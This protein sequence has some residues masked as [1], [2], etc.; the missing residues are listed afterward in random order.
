MRYLTVTANFMG[1]GLKD[2]FE[3]Q[4]NP[5]ELYLTMDL[6][7]EIS[8]WNKAYQPVISMSFDDRHS[9]ADLIKSLDDQGLT[10]ARK[11]KK[12]LG[13][14]YKIDYYSEGQLMHLLV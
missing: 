6:R 1:T 2:K 13:D 8:S 11:I 5:D 12:F 9:N 14:D 4:L 3:G 10:I 7:L